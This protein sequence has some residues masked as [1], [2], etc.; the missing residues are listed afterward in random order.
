MEVE[1]LQSLYPDD[2][3]A[4]S[5]TPSLV[6]SKPPLPSVLTITI[7]PEPLLDRIA[8]NHAVL[9]MQLSYPPLAVPLLPPSIEL[10]A[11]RGVNSELLGV[12]RQL[13]E[14]EKQRMWLED[15]RHDGIMVSLCGLLQEWLRGHNVENVS[16][17]EQMKRR[18]QHEEEERERE[19]LER[20][21]RAERE[22]KE[23]RERLAVEIEQANRRME[24]AMHE[25]KRLRQ[26]QQQHGAAQTKATPSQVLSP[27]PATH[28]VK[29]SSSEEKK[30]QPQ[31]SADMNVREVKVKLAQARQQEKKLLQRERNKQRSG[32]EHRTHMKD[33]DVSTSN[34]PQWAEDKEGG[35]EDESED[36]E[37]E[38]GSGESDEKEGSEADEQ[39]DVDAL[40]PSSFNLSGSLSFFDQKKRNER[41]L[42]AELDNRGKR[43]SS[44]ESD[45]SSEEEEDDSEDES[46]SADG[47]RG[48]PKPRKRTLLHTSP[49]KLRALSHSAN[50]ANE[51]PVLTVSLSRYR[52]D[53]DELQLLGKGG[54]GSV[55]KVRGRVDKLLYAVKKI[56]LKRRGAEENRRIVREVSTI[57]MLHHSYIVRYYQAWIEEEDERERSRAGDEWR[58]EDEQEAG[59]DWLSSSN[60]TSSYLR[61]FDDD[62][63]EEEEKGGRSSRRNSDKSNRP[64]QC[65]YIQMEYCQ[66]AAHQPPLSSLL[67]VCS[68][69]N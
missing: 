67:A 15:V 10:K 50:V 19:R 65:L 49:N 42:L 61:E 35:S 18:E 36:D 59:S 23:R 40:F 43:R 38:S 11:V 47:H 29:R 20:E 51:L 53:F 25:E 39:E 32:K 26:Q 66:H 45:S 28:T 21:M 69:T 2:V 54:F 57:G 64:S 17:H 12:A 31:P 13:V 9:A 58:L 16:F 8:N 56:K 27:L 63:E 5:T 55:Y 44:V 1:A 3:V 68:G 33:D 46:Q 37:D 4:V 34:P 48:T 24:R 14:T 30:E 7:L 60:P 22:E 62:E 6:S 52:N 41:E